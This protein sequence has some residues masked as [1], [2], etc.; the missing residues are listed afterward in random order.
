MIPASIE[1]GPDA[2]GQHRAPD[3]HGRGLTH[4]RGYSAGGLPFRSV[5]QPGRVIRFRKYGAASR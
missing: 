4:A 3:H 5:R 2:S 1:T